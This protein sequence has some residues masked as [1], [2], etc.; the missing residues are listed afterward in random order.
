MDP[1]RVGFPI[2]QDV[3]WWDGSAGT[4]FFIDPRQNM[5][6]VIMAQVSPAR[7]NG[8]REEFSTLVDAAILERR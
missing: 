6:I 8:F 5:I 4:R 1:T 3:Y 2:G 7:G